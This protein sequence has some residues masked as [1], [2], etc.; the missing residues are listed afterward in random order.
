MVQNFI[1]FARLGAMKVRITKYYTTTQLI[2]V[3]VVLMW[4]RHKKLKPQNFSSEGLRC[5]FCTSES[6]P[7]HSILKFSTSLEPN[8]DGKTIF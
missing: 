6:F 5:H 3:S 1:L 2:N 8:Y 7:L 4:R